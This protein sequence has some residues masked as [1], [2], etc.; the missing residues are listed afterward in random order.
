[1][2]GSFLDFGCALAFDAVLCGGIL[3][4]SGAAFA[5]APLKVCLDE[6]RPPYSVAH[7]ETGAGFDVAVSGALAQHLG[8]P[9]QIQWFESK[10]DEDASPTLDANALLSDGRCDIVAGYP[11]V[12]DS[13][14]RPGLSSTR[15]PDFH[16][17]TAKDRGRRVA[18]GTLTP[19]HPYQRSALVL[20]LSPKVS[21]RSVRG[22]DD[23]G[24]LHFG[25][26]G[27]TFGDAILMMY[28]NG[29]LI[30]HITHYPVGQGA[31]LDRLEKG[32]IDASFLSLARFDAYRHDHPQTQ[33]RDSGYLYP[34]A[35]NLG[36][37]TLTTHD[38]L[39][40]QIN[41]AID[42]MRSSGEIASIAK[43]NGITFVEP[44]EPFVSPGISFSQLAQ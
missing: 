4:G 11:L 41:T 30:D 3:L 21:Q 8:R 20:L 24:D 5:Q 13:L 40:A 44:A 9:L 25:V 12:A 39:L 14:G 23:V 7:G 28:Q 19:S 33:I 36:Y 2:R 18:L 26:E 22:L 16:G 29:R 17:A 42:T 38:E 43:Q 27:G 34:I 6:D 37:V 31:L 32:E 1:M 10:M 35:F 15:M